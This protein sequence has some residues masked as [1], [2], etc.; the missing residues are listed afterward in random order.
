MQ[1]VISNLMYFVAGI[2]SFFISRPILCPIAF[3]EKL[4]ITVLN[5]ELAVAN[6]LPT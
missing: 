4:T 6:C 1:T 2:K 5:R 3:I